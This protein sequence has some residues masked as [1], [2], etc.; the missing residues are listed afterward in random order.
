MKRGELIAVI[1]AVHNAIQNV[2]ANWERGDLAGAINR[3]RKLD[4]DKIV[5]CIE[6]WEK[7]D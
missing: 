4:E 2:M 5:P 7:D 6:W 3:L 1:E